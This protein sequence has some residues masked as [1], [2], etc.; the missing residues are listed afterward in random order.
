ML[1]DAKSK[2]LREYREI[3]EDAY[4]ANEYVGWQYLCRGEETIRYF[5][6]YKENVFSVS[7]KQLREFRTHVDA[8]L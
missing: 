8:E 1:S 5:N 3:F 7:L 2:V 6:N 4:E